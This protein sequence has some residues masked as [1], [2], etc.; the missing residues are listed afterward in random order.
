MVSASCCFR[1]L[2]MSII[3]LLE[4]GFALMG[5]HLKIHVRISVVAVLGPFVCPAA[6]LLFVEAY[7]VICL[8]CDVPSGVEEC[9]P[10]LQSECL[11]S[12]L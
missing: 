2:V 5:K 12:Q 11:L 7:F 4:I 3:I 1:F 8:S 10:S 9:L 6:S